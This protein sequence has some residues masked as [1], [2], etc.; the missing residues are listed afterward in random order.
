MLVHDGDPTP[1]RIRCG[2]AATTPILSMMM[3]TTSEGEAEPA[4]AMAI[5]D[6]GSEEDVC[7]A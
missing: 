6:A 1:A 4:V 5:R 2:A 3:P 7:A